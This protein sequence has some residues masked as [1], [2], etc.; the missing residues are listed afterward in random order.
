MKWTAFVAPIEPPLAAPIVLAVVAGYVDACTF[1][2]LFGFFVAQVTGSYVV[3]GANLVA[4][5]SDSTAVLAVPV[6]FAGGVAATVTAI[7]GQAVAGSALAWALTL[8]TLL[9]IGGMAAFAAGTPFV[10]PRATL[11]VVASMFGLAAMGVQSASVRLL[12]KGVGST[13][14]MTTNTSQIAVD[15]TQLL[16]ARMCPGSEDS[17]EISGQHEACRRRFRNGLPLPLGFMAG[18]TVGAIAFVAAGFWALAAP[19]AAVGG[20]ALWAAR[21]ARTTAP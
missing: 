18:T 17:A 16:L 8:E 15:A 11:A 9:L 2:G 7:V 19:V 20:L 12:M 6:F 13:S 1:L 10:D 5:T 21:S 14:V 4:G 3:S